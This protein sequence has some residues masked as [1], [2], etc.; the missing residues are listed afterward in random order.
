MLVLASVL[1]S[2]L[3][4]GLGM[5]V[6]VFVAQSCWT[7]W[8]PMDCS[9]PGSFVHGILQARILEWIAIS[10]S[11]GSFWLRGR[12][13][14]QHCRQ[15]LCPWATG[16]VPPHWGTPLM[17]KGVWQRAHDPGPT[18][19]HRKASPEA[20]VGPLECWESL[21]EAELRCQPRGDR[22]QDWSAT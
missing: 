8:D 11:R 2:E 5:K 1:G 3:A 16:A 9:L 20:A 22:L 21:L 6:K 10:L 18:D 13:H 19:L 12:T 17:T 4:L 14:L 7:L 15:I